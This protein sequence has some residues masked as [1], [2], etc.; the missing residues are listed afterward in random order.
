[1]STKTKTWGAGLLQPDVSL[2]D[3]VTKYDAVFTWTGHHLTGSEILPM[4]LKADPLA[5]AAIPFLRGRDFKDVAL[6][7]DCPR[8]V[9]SLLDQTIKVP[10]WVDLD[11]IRRGQDFYWE[12]FHSCGQ[13]M[14]NHSLISDFAVSSIVR[15]L[16]CTGYLAN[17]KSAY[18]RGAETAY[19]VSRA[20]ERGQ[21]VPWGR[22]WSAV[23]AV[24]LMHAQ[25]RIHATRISKRTN[26][27]LLGVAINQQDLMF[28][29]LLFSVTVILGYDKLGIKYTLQQ[30]DDYIATFRYIGYLIG[31]DDPRCL[32]GDF[33]T[34][35][36][37]KQSLDMYLIQPNKESAHMARVVIE[38]FENN[39]PYFL[40]FR[41]HAQ[42]SRLLMGESLANEMQLPYPNT[43]LD[44]FLQ[45]YILYHNSTL[46]LMLWFRREWALSFLER[47]VLNSFQALFRGTPTFQFRPLE[48]DG[49]YSV[50]LD[51]R[52][53]FPLLLV[54][55]AFV[56]ILL[57]K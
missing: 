12:T 31:V 6:G 27:P 23:V 50:A 8:Q 28:T 49:D 5:D 43:G 15:V 30:R 42:L 19:M 14:M 38:G 16:T 53:H 3:R 45:L 48:K 39:P 24:R 2:G 11:Q 29:L 44:M 56:A 47:K 17:P 10:E 41:H 7:D 32:L 54:V 33:T 13:V 21:L 4:A 25:A 34:A 22:G 9:Q 51:K 40:S 35:L 37:L 55:L 20:M 26:K 36:A 52:S 18:R 46:N 1:M 57:I